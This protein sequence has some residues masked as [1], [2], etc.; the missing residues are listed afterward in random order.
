MGQG[1]DLR[2]HPG[3]PRRNS[4]RSQRQNHHRKGHVVGEPLNILNIGIVGCGNIIAQYLKTL[5]SLDRLRLVA[6]ADLDVSR[7]EAVAADLPGVRALSVQD[8]MDDDEVQLVL[9]LTIPAAH[10]DVA[11]QAI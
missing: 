7:A 5:P 11:L 1:P 6:V 9:N 3:A 10:A 2:L 4:S 8:L